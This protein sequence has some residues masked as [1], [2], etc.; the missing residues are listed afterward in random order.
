MSRKSAILTGSLR[1]LADI[2][3]TATVAR[4]G[5][6]QMF[7][8]NAKGLRKLRHFPQQRCRPGQTS[9]RHGR[10]RSLSILRRGDDLFE[11]GFV[12][13]RVQVGVFF[14]PDKPAWRGLVDDF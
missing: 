4:Q 7:S 12:A 8:T 14:Q 1:P 10:N 9:L 3:N 13:N 2:V 11:A 6:D 5:A